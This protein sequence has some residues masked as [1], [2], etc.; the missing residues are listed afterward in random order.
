MWKLRIIKFQMALRD[1][2]HTFRVRMTWEYVRSGWDE[3]GDYCVYQKS[4]E[5]RRLPVF[6]KLIDFGQ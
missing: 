1:A 5:K 2:V 6:K 3:H 4:E